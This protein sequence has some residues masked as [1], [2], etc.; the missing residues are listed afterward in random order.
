MHTH[1][2]NGGDLIRVPNPAHT[3][4]YDEL[5]RLIECTDQNK[6]D[7]CR[8]YLQY[9]RS[10]LFRESVME[11]VYLETEYREHS[12]DS[13]YVI[14]A[15]V[16]ES[17]GVQRV[18]AYVWESKA[19]QCYIFERDT[20]NRLKPSQDLVQA[21]NQLLHYYLDLKGSE[22]S[23][24]EFGVT[25]SDDFCL[26]GIIIGCNRTRVRG[27]YEEAKKVRLYH[28]AWQTRKILYGHEGIRLMTWDHVLEQIKPRSELSPGSPQHYPIVASKISAGPVPVFI[29]PRDNSEE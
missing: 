14:S 11:L 2:S 19:P 12:G 22:P 16:Q 29:D 26:G 15:Q 3:D 27:D 17:S 28:K 4:P 13:D 10:L 18:K 23:R 6:E 21:E 20:D 25:T 9:A 5:R 7:A 8:F 24:D 1:L